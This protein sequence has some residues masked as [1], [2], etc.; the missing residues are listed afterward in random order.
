MDDFRC[1]TETISDIQDTLIEIHGTLS[2]LLTQARS[3]QAILTNPENWQ[4]D[5][6]LVGTAFLDLVV[7]YHEKLD[8]GE[9]GGPVS[10]AIASLNE[11]LEHDE[12]F[13]KQWTDY[14]RLSE[15]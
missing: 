12:N 13:Y 11:Y 7:Q 5:A 1:V 10:E 15:V 3:V 8:S 4:G 14:Q 6:Q 9:G 2:D